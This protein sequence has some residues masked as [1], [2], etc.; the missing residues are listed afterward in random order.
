MPKR[1]LK[2]WC[3]SLSYSLVSMFTY[4]GSASHGPN[5]HSVQVEFVEFEGHHGYAHKYICRA[6]EL[7]AIIRSNTYLPYTFET[8]RY[9]LYG[10]YRI[11]FKDLHSGTYIQSV[12]FWDWK[13]WGV[14]H[15]LCVWLLYGRS[16]VRFP[17]KRKAFW[18]GFFTD[19]DQ[20]FFR[21]RIQG[22]FQYGS[23][24]R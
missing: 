24:F 22:F 2:I 12:A 3:D 8:I 20:G 21:I 18:A 14:G 7:P 16:R 5:F 10:M 6:P 13:G 11:F 9:L 23:G 4:L 17:D 19:P 15:W 1:P